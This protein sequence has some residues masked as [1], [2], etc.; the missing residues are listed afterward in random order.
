MKPSLRTLILAAAAAL[1]LP[2]FAA[3]Y[4]PP[5]VV[6]QPVEEVPVEVGSGWYLRGDIGYNFSLD[7]RGDFDFRNFDP[8]SGT[9][10]PDAFDTASL[11]DERHLGRRLRL[12]FHRHDPRRLHGSTASARTSTAPRRARALAWLARPLSVRAAVPRTMPMRRR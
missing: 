11:G 10:S 2:A 8:A 6:D 1:P 5:I 3:D 7:A 4:D 12:Q 9:Y